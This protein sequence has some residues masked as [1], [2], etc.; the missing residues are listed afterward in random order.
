MI[1]TKE[2]LASYGI[3]EALTCP[4]VPSEESSLEVPSVAGRWL[5]SFRWGKLLKNAKEH[6]ALFSVHKRKE[7]R[8]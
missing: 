1:P 6:F 3:P 5:E 4:Y 8:Q 2:E 7:L